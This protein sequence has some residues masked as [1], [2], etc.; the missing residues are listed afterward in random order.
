MAR[1]L[2]AHSYFL[3]FD[4]KARAQMQ[5]YPPLGTLYAAAVLRDAGHD[6][7][8]FDAM[9]A[10]D[11]NEFVPALDGHNPDIVIFYEDNFH[12]LNKMCLTRMRE[13]CLRMAGMARTRGA[14][15]LAQG[16]DPVDH[17]AEYLARG[18][19]A[20]ICGEGEE[21]AREAADAVSDGVLRDAASIRGLAYYGEGGSIVFTPKRPL[22]R[23]LDAL[24]FPAWD[25]VDMERYRAAW[26][27]RH[28]FFSL[29]V[30]TTRGCPYSCNWCAKPVYGQVYH[31]RSPENVASE[32]ALLRERYA[33]DHI[34]FCDDILGLKPGW[35][36]R[37]ADCLKEKDC[38][39]P[40]SCQTRADLMLRD[41]NARDIARAGA[42]TVWIGAESGSQQILDA[43]DKGTT[44]AHI[45]EATQRL[46]EAGVDVA[47]FLQFGY[48]GESGDDVRAT[49]RLLRR[50]RPDDIGISVSYP[51][52]GTPFYERVA[53]R[54][55][56]KKNWAE[57]GDLDL[58]YPGTYRPAYYRALH[59]AVHKEFRMRQAL[60]KRSP[61]RL[62]L[63]PANFCQWVIARARM[64]L[65]RR[66]PPSLPP[67]VSVLPS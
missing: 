14:V 28:G 46:Q 58:M 6:V 26:R 35:L 42:R 18:V 39:I 34:W 51:L 63:L 60:R 23:D 40:F 27:K 52:P 36:A 19:D 25:L 50:G 22:I 24:P 11:E 44:T 9:F 29:N 65:L 54:L 59:T 12:Y 21:T 61:R 47:W 55:G 67:R 38:L 41:N 43:M 64:A 37:Y 32:V 8:L 13:A 20:V 56:E 1:I 10:A 2:L 31:S 53:A 3:R 66:L 57:S 49:L 16:S 30:V 4:A 17:A 33:P 7:A 62:V 45:L 48:L 15:V 5:P